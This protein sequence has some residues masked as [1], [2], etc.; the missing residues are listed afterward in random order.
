MHGLSSSL[1]RAMLLVILLLLA[2]PP[3]VAARDGVIQL[4]ASRAAAGG[5]TAGDSP[6]HPVTISESGS[7]R[8]VGNLVTASDVS[9]IEITADHVTLDLNGFSLTGIGSGNEEGI[10]IIGPRTDVEIRDGSVHDFGDAGIRSSDCSGCRVIRVRV[11]DNGW[12][13]VLLGGQGNLIRDSTAW[14]NG[15][16]GL[17]ANGGSSF[18]RNVSHNNNTFGISL[19]GNGGTIA[20]NT[21]YDNNSSGLAARFGGHAVIRS[22]ASFSNGGDGIE[23]TG[24]SVVVDNSVAN[25]TGHGLDL[26]ADCGYGGNVM[27]GNTAGT[28][29]AGVQI[30]SNICEGNAS[31]P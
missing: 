22:N 6:G 29:D 9:A 14:S 25:N 16:S 23:A 8:L 28:V 13:G 5:V 20:N 30:D 18:L 21:V 10:A 3:T 2:A 24:G 4:N 15:S 1:F 31:C 17:Y 19:S 11:F 26:T 12:T 7:Y 27:R